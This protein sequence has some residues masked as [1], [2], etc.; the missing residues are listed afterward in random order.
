MTF[1]AFGQFP[2]LSLWF[3][4]CHTKRSGAATKAGGLRTPTAIPKLCRDKRLP[5]LRVRS[6]ALQ[7]P[8]WSTSLQALVNSEE[9][10]AESVWPS[11]DEW[12]SQVAVQLAEHAD[13]ALVPN[14]RQILGESRYRFHY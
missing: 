1:P 2:S 11:L 8:A 4:D 13:P 5:R 7:F 14:P 3:A 10:F 6:R 9:N 12:R